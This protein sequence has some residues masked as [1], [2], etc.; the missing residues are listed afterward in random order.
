MPPISGSRSPIS[1]P[2]IGKQPLLLL[3]RAGM[4]FRGM[5]VDG[6]GADAARRRDEG[7]MPPRLLLVDREIVVEG[8]Q[9]G[10]DHALRDVILEAGHAEL[11]FAAFY[12]SECR[13]NKGDGAAAVPRAY[14]WLGY[15]I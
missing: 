10:R 3:E 2:A 5:T 9:G 11:L 4:H 14:P 12:S 6:D 7:Q 13:Q 8:E 15:F 1:S